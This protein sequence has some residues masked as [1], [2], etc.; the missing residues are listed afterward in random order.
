MA[1]VDLGLPASKHLF[2]FN[3][4]TKRV[5]P[6]GSILDFQYVN[7]TVAVRFAPGDHLEWLLLQ[8]DSAD[9]A[10]KDHTKLYKT[11][12]AFIE[13]S[14]EK[15]NEKKPMG[16]VDAVGDC[17]PHVSDDEDCDDYYE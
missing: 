14:S 12:S 9:N 4:R 3:D 5:I 1:G 11:L 13:E 16:F 2:A 6:L 10:K 7:N 17:T 8:Y 15:E